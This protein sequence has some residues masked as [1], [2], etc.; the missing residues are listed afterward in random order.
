MLSA[1]AKTVTVDNDSTTIRTS[2]TDYADELEKIRM[3]MPDIEVGIWISIQP[4]YK[5]SN[6][7][8]RI[9]MQNLVDVD[10]NEKFEAQDIDARVKRLRLRFDG[11][12]YTPKLT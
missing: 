11:Y 12:I 10:F 4:K 9:R 1:S 7:T 5:R 2:D 8:M 3:H 6:L